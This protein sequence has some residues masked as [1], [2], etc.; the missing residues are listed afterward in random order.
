KEF[1]QKYGFT[2]TTRSPNY[3]QSNGLGE[4]AVKIVKNIILKEDDWQLGLLIYRNSPLENGYSPAQLS[5]NRTLREVL[6]I[7][8]SKLQAT[9]PDR[10]Q[11]EEREAIRHSRIQ[12]N[13][14]AHHGVRPLP[15]LTPGSKVFVKDVKQFGTIIQKCEEPRSYLMETSRGA[16]IR[17]NRIGLVPIQGPIQD[18]QIEESPAKLSRPHREIRLPSRYREML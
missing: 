7:H 15:E 6:P 5:M 16:T 18:T 2:L 1:T 14:D 11:V 12:R 3:P 4:A 17:R 10:D 8:E 13:Y 9:V